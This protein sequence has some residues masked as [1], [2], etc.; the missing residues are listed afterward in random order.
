M[1]LLYIPNPTQYLNLITTLLTIKTKTQD[2][3]MLCHGSVVQWVCMCFKTT[4]QTKTTK[5]NAALNI[6]SCDKEI[7]VCFVY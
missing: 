2:S 3:S 6:S 1:S 5:Y 7:C 4:D